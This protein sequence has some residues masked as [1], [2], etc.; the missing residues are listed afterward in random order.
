MT[1]PGAGYRAQGVFM[2]ALTVVAVLVA[3]WWSR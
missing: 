3:W 2:A 1:T